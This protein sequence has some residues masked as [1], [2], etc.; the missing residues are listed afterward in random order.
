[1]SS[2]QPSLVKAEVVAQNSV[3][4]IVP[5]ANKPMTLSLCLLCLAEKQ[6]KVK[7]VKWCSEYIFEV[8]PTYKDTFVWTLLDLKHF[9]NLIHHSPYNNQ[10]LTVI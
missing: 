3:S 6:K 4:Y 10:S 9:V 7:W 2:A 8:K 1:M 5:L